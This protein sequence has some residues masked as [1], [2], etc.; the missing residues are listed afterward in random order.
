M[1]SE[2]TALLFSE[3]WQ[4][5]KMTL[6]NWGVYEGGPFEIEFATSDDGSLTV[7]GGNTGVGK[8]QIID[9]LL[10]LLMKSKVDLNRASEEVQKGKRKRDLFTYVK[11]YVGAVERGGRVI[12][13]YLRGTDESTGQPQAAWSFISADL[14]SAHGSTLCVAG[15]IW[16]GAGDATTATPI[17]VLSENHLD[18]RKAER[19]SGERFTKQ[20]VRSIY[21]DAQLVSDNKEDMRRQ[22]HFLTG[23]SEKSENLLYRNYTSGGGTNITSTFRDAVLETPDSIEAAKSL[24]EAYDLSFNS[25]ANARVQ[26]EVSRQLKDIEVKY[27]GYEATNRSLSIFGTW[28]SEHTSES[29]KSELERWF[30]RKSLPSIDEEIGLVSAAREAA[31]SQLAEAEER[32]AEAK[33]LESE[34]S[35]DFYQKGGGRI[36]SLEAQLESTKSTLDARTVAR[37][38]VE[39]L[40][41]AIDE[42]VPTS[43]AAWDNRVG[44][45][46][47]DEQYQ[48][49][50]ESK[51]T[52]FSQ[53][54]Q[55][56]AFAKQNADSIRVELSTAERTG[57]RITREMEKSREVLARA[58]G[59]SLEEMPY[60]CELMDLKE[61]EEEWRTAANYAF[62]RVSDKIFIAAL[63]EREFRARIEKTDAEEVGRRQNFRFVNLDDAEFPTAKEGMISSKLKFDTTS[64]FAPHVARAVMDRAVDM[65][66]V[67]SG[68][69]FREGVRRQVSKKGQ[70]KTGR[71]GAY[72]S[73]KSRR[74]DIIGFCDEVFLESLRKRLDDAE[75]EE[76]RLGEKASRLM[77]EADGIKSERAAATAARDTTWDSID[78]EAS[79]RE[80]VSLEAQLDEARR[81]AEINDLESQLESAK[82]RVLDLVEK[83]TQI[84]SDLESADNKVEGLKA[85][86]E[87][88]LEL[89]QRR[90]DVLEASEDL[91]EEFDAAWDVCIGGQVRETVLNRKNYFDARRRLQE[92][93][94]K[95]AEGLRRNLLT[96]KNDIESRL[97]TFKATFEGRIQELEGLD[98]SIR[99]CESFIQIPHGGNWEEAL[100]N[101]Q[102]QAIKKLLGMLYDF[103]SKVKRYEAE[104]NDT[105]RRIGDVLAGYPY[106]REGARLR[107]R[108]RFSY[109]GD[110][111][112]VNQQIERLI[113]EQYGTYDTSDYKAMGARERESILESVGLIV[114]KVYGGQ[115]QR[116]NVY[117]D[118]RRRFQMTAQVE[119]PDGR[120]PDVVDDFASSSGG[121][122]EKTKAFIT[123]AAMAYAL[124]TPAN[125]RPRFAPII[126]DEAFVKSDLSTTR[127]AVEVLKGLGFQTIVSC[128]DHKLSSV[129]PI[130]ERG[131]FVTRPVADGPSFISQDEIADEQLTE[132]V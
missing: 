9:A 88:V 67:E 28:G 54:S 47:T 76:E 99:C 21:P 20:S 16:V 63:S 53:L 38:R 49:D 17:W 84:S 23:T 130:A 62:A 52:E 119:H 3:H 132:Y 105:V 5:H 46:Q 92:H 51:M 81:A 25:F 39:E 4:V 95:M 48:K 12:P 124:G 27:R 69:D 121:E 94:A 120:E 30:A 90:T 131:C 61:G 73:P 44:L 50:F 58:S 127:L 71:D 118:P 43:R 29:D 98:A 31:R 6:I 11:G 112:R 82:Q 26:V 104:V 79:K 116:S 8:S 96:Q 66:F 33:R 77:R 57:T 32:L 68:E 122:K 42:D 109:S 35:S 41:K 87:E 2:K 117:N 56:G 45:F 91:V 24:A 101:D 15:L 65:A 7:I 113:R 40:F 72:G 126:F 107:L 85:W 89:S 93:V 64:P 14:R 1:S 18:G 114:H 60:G 59:L 37:K 75:K 74:L 22:L 100:A 110:Y 125:S 129:Y 128:P 83:K 106:D 19:I 55:E 103:A 70:T 80:I 111:A 78:I 108:P 97:R 36:A 10:V 102:A 86:R 115:N 34:L 123:A 13:R